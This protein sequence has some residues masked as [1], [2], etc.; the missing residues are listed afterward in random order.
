MSFQKGEERFKTLIALSTDLL[1]FDTDKSLSYAKEAEKLAYELKDEKKVAIAHFHI[2]YARYRA[3][4]YTGALYYFN[5]SCD[6]LKKLKEEVTLSQ[7]KLYVAFVY[8]DMKRYDL[9]LE[10]MNEQLLFYSKKNMMSDYSSVLLGVS[11]IFLTKKEYSKALDGYFKCL[12]IDEKIFPINNEVIAVEYCNI[13]E[14]YYWLQKYD[15]SYKYRKM[16]L[17]LYKKMNFM[18]GIANLEMDIGSTL[19]K[20][21]DYRLAE[22]YLK[23]ALIN[24][25]TIKYPFG[26]RKIKENFVHLYLDTHRY[27]N[28]LRECSELESLSVESKDS[29]EISTCYNLFADIYYSV[30]SYKQSA[31]YY[32]KYIEL[33][34]ELDSKQN[35]QKLMELQ[36]VFET[37]QKDFENKILRQ[38]NDLQKEKL[39]A[40]GNLLIAVSCG[41]VIAG[42]LLFILFLKERKIR[43]INEEIKIRNIKLEEHIIT[44]DKFFSILAH[45]LK[46]PFWAILGQNKLLEDEYSNLTDGERKEIISRVGISAGTVYKLFEDLLKWAKTQNDTIKTNIQPLIV[47]RLIESAIKP[48]KIIANNKNVLLEQECDDNLEIKADKF[49]METVIGNFVDNAIK[50]SHQNGKIIVAGNEKEKEIEISIQDFGAGMPQ[51]KIDRL[52]KLGE[53]VS[54]AGTM[55]E[56]GT[57]LGLIICKEFVEKHGGKISVSSRVGEGT[58]FKVILPKN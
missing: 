27:D 41:I 39:D 8:T 21:K 17:E 58:I 1:F 31:E 20:L 15:L 32:K 47:N 34:E 23:N 22:Q 28:A 37:E 26:I 4:D 2:G 33:K 54:S 52:F 12:E 42:I 6:I 45:N 35:K 38:E 57:G 10:I 46:N 29:T 50:Y 49:M 7:T 43:G 3:C 14:A 48:Y 5:S 13:G 36:T 30:K 9:A 40:K 16:S 53:D 18:D 55:N 56:K 51:E 19:M 11:N 44:K 24:Y 25:R